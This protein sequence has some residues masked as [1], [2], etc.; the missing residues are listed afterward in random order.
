MTSKLNPQHF[1][2]YLDANM[3]MNE[4]LELARHT[5]QID[6][7]VAI[8]DCLVEELT[9]YINEAESDNYLAVQVSTLIADL[10]HPVVHH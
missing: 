4:L 10:A 3:K 8:I 9:T 5:D 1:G 6:G 2:D 7:I